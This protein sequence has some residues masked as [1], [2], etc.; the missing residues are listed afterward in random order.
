[1][2]VPQT[3]PHLGVAFE[4]AEKRYGGIVALRQVS[5]E[6]RAGEFVALLGPNGAGKSTLLKMAALLVRPTSGRVSF[7]GADGAAPTALKQRMGMVGHHT[8]LYEEFS[9]EEN[10]LFFARLYGV[11]GLPTRVAAALEAAGLAARAGDLVRTFSRGMRQRL[12]IARALLPGPSLLLLDEPATGLDRQGVGWLA[13]TLQALH[14][15]GCTM[16]MSTHTQNE[17][18]DIAS[19]AVSLAAGRV[20]H[21]SGYGGDPRLLLAGVR[22]ET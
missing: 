2:G 4:R 19:R 20:E 16:L 22:A 13:Q 9:A 1:L 12:A 17:T 7:S 10:L 8:F 11:S 18:L 3:Q 15:E 21:D 14:R 5:I 6:F